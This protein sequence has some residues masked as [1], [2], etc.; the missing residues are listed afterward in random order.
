MAGWI[1]SAQQKRD[2]D[3]QR[4]ICAADGHPGTAEDPLVKTTDGWRV[5][6]SD[7]TDPNNG[8]YGQQQTEG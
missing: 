2:H 6:L 4:N 8:F 1:N 5:H 7:T 3:G